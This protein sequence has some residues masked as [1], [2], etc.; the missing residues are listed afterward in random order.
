MSDALPMPDGPSGL[1]LSRDLLFTSKVTSEA[2]A[3]GTRVLVA[4]NSALALAMIDQWRPRVLFLDLAAGE[5][6][7][8]AAILAY[9]QAAGTDVPLVA[10]G[11]HVD[12]AGLA[13]AHDAGC[14]LVLPRSKFTHDLPE[15]IGRYLLPEPLPGS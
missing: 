1:L 6:T 5:L 4:G 9:R 14:D 12:T 3:Q 11:S 13:A 15:L 8:P 2:R 10:F 7:S